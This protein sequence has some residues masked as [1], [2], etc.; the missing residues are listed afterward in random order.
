MD[1][2]SIFSYTMINSILFEKQN[3]KAIG[4]DFMEKEGKGLHLCIQRG[5][6]AL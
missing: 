5:A 6:G 1:N 4:N 2:F 3:R